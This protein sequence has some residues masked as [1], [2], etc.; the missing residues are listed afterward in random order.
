MQLASFIHWVLLKVLQS[1]SRGAQSAILVIARLFLVKNS[2][3]APRGRSRSVGLHRVV[4]S[5]MAAEQ[6]SMNKRGGI[7]LNKHTL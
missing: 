7:G 1:M 4:P 3:L 5:A 6:A 2:F